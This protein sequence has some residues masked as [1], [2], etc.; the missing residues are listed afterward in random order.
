MKLSLIGGL[1]RAAPLLPTT[2]EGSPAFP[3]NRE[4]PSASPK[5]EVS[6]RN[7]QFSPLYGTNG[8]VQAA[9]HLVRRGGSST[10]FKAIPCCGDLRA[11]A[12]WP[13]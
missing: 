5:G 1:V 3:G 12:L 4:P 13:R 9:E 2:E 10:T 6:S 8:A 7:L 11:A